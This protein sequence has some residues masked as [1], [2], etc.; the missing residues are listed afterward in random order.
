MTLVTSYAEVWIEIFARRIRMKREISSPPTR[1]CGL[2]FRLPSGILHFL[3]V[4]SYAEVWI[5]ILSLSLCYIVL[6][7]TSYAEVWIEIVLLIVLR[8]MS[9]VTSYAEV[10]IEIPVSPKYPLTRLGHLLRGGVD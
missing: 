5:E 2:K 9:S 3:R 10:W 8:S 1:R 4:T 7:V 6:H